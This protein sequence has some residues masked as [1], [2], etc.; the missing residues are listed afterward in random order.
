MFAETSLHATSHHSANIRLYVMSQRH[1]VTLTLIGLSYERPYL[2][3][4]LNL[5]MICMFFAC[6]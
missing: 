6:V 2:V 5:I 3:L 4:D 1:D